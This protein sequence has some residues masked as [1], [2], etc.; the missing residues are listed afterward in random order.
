MKPQLLSKNFSEKLFTKFEKFELRNKFREKTTFF[1]TALA[2]HDP[3]HVR[4]T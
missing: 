1:M 4:I 2:L 3:G